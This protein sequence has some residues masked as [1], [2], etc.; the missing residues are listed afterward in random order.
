MKTLVKLC[1]LGSLAISLMAVA[2]SAMA[3][4][5]PSNTRIPSLELNQAD[6][7]D[8][9]STLFN[10]VKDV[11]YMVA[12]DVVGVVTARL[13]DVTFET[14]LRNIL[15]QVNATYRVEG[16]VYQ[17]LLKE[18]PNVTGGTTTPD[19]PTTSTDNKVTLRI[20]IRSSDPAYIIGMLNGSFQPG[21]PPEISA[22]QGR[23]MMGGM[24][25]MGGFGGGMGGFGGGMGGFG[26]GMGGFGGGMGG[27]GGGMGGFG[28]GMGGGFG[29]GM[30]GRSGGFGGGMGGGRGGRGF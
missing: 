6:V 8:A 24:G 17:I 7:R 5:D 25:G 12:P 29:G 10:N 15:Q 2:P 9:L 27:F 22:M 3:Q 1:T 23:G 30:G 19:L 16:G 13:K 20:K 18:V 11:S 14:A 4:N 26:G 28:G 21:T